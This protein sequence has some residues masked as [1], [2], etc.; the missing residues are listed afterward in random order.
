MSGNLNICPMVVSLKSQ[1]TTVRVPVR[2]CNLSAYA[3]QLPK[4]LLC[5]L[6]SVN[7]VDSWT[8][9]SSQKPDK[10]SN[11]N[12]DLEQLEVSIDTE[13]LLPDQVLRAKKK[14]WATGQID[15]QKSY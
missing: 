9:D 6:N 12:V 14:Y 13:N 3:V 4:S 7:V 2:V 15:F 10:E 5:T 8:P 11:G 1:G